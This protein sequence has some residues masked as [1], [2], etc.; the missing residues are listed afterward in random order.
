[1]NKSLYGLKYAL[2]DWYENI[3]CFLINISFKWC[4]SF[5]S[6]YVL[7][8]NGETLIV[9]LYVDD[10]VINVKDTNMILGLK[11]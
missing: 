7:H 3:D 5:H 11:K 10:R 8:V 1:M 9:L 4:A 6:I 2:R